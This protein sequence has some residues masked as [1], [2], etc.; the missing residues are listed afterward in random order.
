[1]RATDD[2]PPGELCKKTGSTSGDPSAPDFVEWVVDASGC[3][4]EAL[5]SIA[6]MQRLADCIVREARVTVVGLPAWHAFPGE[7]GVTGLYLL[8]E[9]HLALHTYPEHGFFSANLY[10]CGPP[11]EVAW[12]ALLTKHA[13]AS[14]IEVR[15]VRRRLPASSG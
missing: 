3:D 13:G 11:R 5:R 14:A 9:S 10:S 7:G 2:E 8:S 1:M 4:P 6:T 15:A 12:E